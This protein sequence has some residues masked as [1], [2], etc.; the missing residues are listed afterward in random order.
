MEDGGQISGEIKL[1]VTCYSMG[2]EDR[3]DERIRWRAENIVLGAQ[4]KEGKRRIDVFNHPISNYQPPAL[5]M[6]RHCAVS[7]VY[8]KG[9]QALQAIWFL[10]SRSFLG[11]EYEACG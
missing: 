7:M 2:K 4:F 11:Y 5:D 6:D 10:F 8:Y 1:F 3:G 9:K